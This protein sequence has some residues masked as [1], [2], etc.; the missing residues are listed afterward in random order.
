MNIV[1]VVVL[2]KEKNK[3][4][5]FSGDPLFLHAHVC[6]CLLKQHRVCNT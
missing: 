1:V 2:G 3:K 5:V 4:G 6:S